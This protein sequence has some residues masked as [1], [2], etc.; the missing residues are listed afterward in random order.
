MAKPRTPAKTGSKL[1]PVKPK[2]TPATPATPAKYVGASPKLAKQVAASLKAANGLQKAVYTA[3]GTPCVDMSA[4]PKNAAA[5]VVGLALGSALPNDTSAA[6]AKYLYFVNVAGAYM[7]TTGGTG[8]VVNGCL[9]K[10][11]TEPSPKSKY[12]LEAKHMHVLDATRDTHAGSQGRWAANGTYAKACSA[13]NTWLEDDKNAQALC[14]AMATRAKQIGGDDVPK[15][16]RVTLQ[17]HAAK[18]AKA[19]R[20]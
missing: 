2:A 1:A 9:N 17:R 20:R 11:N 4:L 7:A 3:F 13:A 10:A 8:G 19:N 15:F 18:W 5:Y 12:Y 16:S 14:V 6:Q